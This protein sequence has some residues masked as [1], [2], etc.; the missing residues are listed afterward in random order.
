MDALLRLGAW[1]TLRNAAGQRAV[2]V[3]LAV[4][5]RA[6]ERQLT[7][8]LERDV[9]PDLL[10]AIESRFHAVIRERS[11]KL[12]REHELRLPPL[13]PLCERMNTE[14]WFAVPGMYGGFR[15]WLEGQGKLTKLVSESWCRVMGGAG[16]RHEITSD[17]AKL[18]RRRLR[19]A[20]AARRSRNV[21]RSE[22]ATTSESSLSRAMSSSL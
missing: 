11:D 9:P 4:G 14:F 13:E 22:N 17:E 1:R 8:V 16:Q 10:R 15:F 7:P 20:H 21:C 12:V 6:L 5:H 2:D 19:L 18:V 3:A